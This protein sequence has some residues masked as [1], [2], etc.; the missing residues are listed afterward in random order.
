MTAYAETRGEMKSVEDLIL[1]EEMQ[2]SR[3]KANRK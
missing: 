3:D 1:E 2:K